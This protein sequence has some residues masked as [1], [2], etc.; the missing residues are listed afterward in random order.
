MAHIC[1]EADGCDHSY[2]HEIEIFD[3]LIVCDDINAKCTDWDECE[4]HRV[5]CIPFGIDFGIEEL[6]E[7]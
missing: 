3:Y 5:R 7:L 1:G 4:F 6:F 2:P